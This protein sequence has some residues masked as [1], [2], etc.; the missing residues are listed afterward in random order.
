[1]NNSRDI[2]KKR[3]KKPIFHT[4]FAIF[5]QKIFVL[6]NRAQS[7]FRTHRDLSSCQKSEQINEPIF[8]KSSGHTDGQTDRRT[9]RWVQKSIWG[10]FSGKNKLQNL[11]LETKCYWIFQNRLFFKMGRNRRGYIADEPK[12]R[13]STFFWWSAHF[14][15]VRFVDNQQKHRLQN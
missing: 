8:W 11:T 2:L 1:M 7:L 10:P 15:F 9:R 5:G 13:R 6:K 3:R 14:F 4:Y 12:M